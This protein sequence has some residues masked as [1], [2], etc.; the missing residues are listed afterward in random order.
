MGINKFERTSSARLICSSRGSGGNTGAD[1]VVVFANATGV[2]VEGAASDTTEAEVI[3][4]PAAICVL[5]GTD[6]TLTG[7][8]D[9]DPAGFG[10]NDGCT[11]GIAEEEGL[12]ESERP[13][14]DNGVSSFGLESSAGGAVVVVEVVMVVGGSISISWS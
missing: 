5:E 2:V 14:G 4:P 9:L 7:V 1:T 8:P 3:V 10:G 13:G 12:G 6:S 11:E